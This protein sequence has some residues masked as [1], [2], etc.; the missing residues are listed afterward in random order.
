MS[1]SLGN[2]KGAHE[3]RVSVPLML[4][5]APAFKV[6]PTSHKEMCVLSALFFV[7][8]VVWSKGCL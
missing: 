6:Y 1:R 2:D 8:G 7:A 5:M 3:I 4:R